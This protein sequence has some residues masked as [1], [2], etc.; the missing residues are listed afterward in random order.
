MENSKK[1]FIAGINADDSFFAHTEADNLDALNVRVVSS[2][3]GKAGSISNVNGTRLVPNYQSFYNVK[4]VGSY[5]DFTTN[6]VFYFLVNKDNNVST[7]YCYKPEEDNIF[8]VLSDNNLDSTYSLNFNPDKPITG[9]GYIDDILYWTGVDGREPFRINVERGIK[10]NHTDYVTSENAYVTPISKSIVTLIRKPPM[11]PLQITVME[12]TDRDTSFLKSRSHT[13]AYRYVY[14]D[15]ETSVF[16]PTSY[17][18][19]NQDIDDDNHKTSRKIKV[20]FPL[21]EA[22]SYGISQDVHKIQ[23]AVKFDKDTSYFIWK[24]FDN[25]THATEFAAQKNNIEGAISADFYNDVLGFAVDDVN[26]IKLYDTIPYEAEALSIA[27][28]RLFL[29]NIKEGRLNTRQLKS[30]DIDLNIITQSFSDSFNQYDR[31]RGG[32]VSFSHASAYQIGLAFFDFAGRTGGVLTDNAMKVITPERELEL[33]AYNAFINFNLNTE[34]ANSIIPD[35]AEYYAIVRTK[36]LIKDFTITNLSD[37]IRYYKIDSNGGFSVFVEN[38]YPTNNENDNK[39]ISGTPNGTFSDNQHVT[40]DPN[41]EGVAIGLGDLTSYKQGYTYQEGDRI[42][43]ITKDRIIEMAITGQEGRYV[44]CNLIDLNESDYLNTTVL[45]ALDYSIIYEIYSPHKI[46]PNEFYYEAFNGRIIESGGQRTYSDTSGNLIGDVYVRSLAADLS[47]IEDHFHEGKQRST[48]SQDSPIQGNVAY[49]DFPIFYGSGENDLSANTGVGNYTESDDYRYDIKINS[50]GSTDTFVWRRRSRVQLGISTSYSSP[51]SITGSA[52]SLSGGVVI[53]FENTTGHTLNDRWVVSAKTATNSNMDQLA[54]KTMALYKPPP[55][56]TILQG[57]RIKIY[58]IE[59]RNPVGPNNFTHEW[60][61][62]YP[63]NLITETFVSLEELF[64]ETTFGTQ[65]ASAFQNRKYAFSFRRGKMDNT[66]GGNQRIK[67]LDSDGTAPGANV[68]LSDGSDI[69]MIVESRETE[70]GGG[71]DVRTTYSL[72][73]DFA[74]EFAYKSESMNPSNDYFL[75][76]I[77]ITGKPNLVPSEVSSQKKTTGIVFSETKIPGSKINGLSK[78]SALD[79]KR[80]DDA[81]GPLR[82]LQVTSKTQSTGSVL[83]AVSENETTGIYLGEQQL[84]QT[85]SGGQFLAVSSGVIGTMNTLRGSYGTSHP[86]SFVVNEGKAFWFDVK[87]ETVIKYDNNGL[88]AIGDVKMK[89]FFK[90]K[91]NIINSDTIRHF[92]VGTYDDYNS[93]YILTIPRTGEVTT[94]LQQDPYYPDTPVIEIT[95]EGSEPTSKVV[96]VEIFKPWEMQFEMTVIDG[97]GTITFNSP[98]TFTIPSGV[99][100]T[101]S[102]SNITVT[103]ATTGGFTSSN[104]EF[105]GS[106]TLTISGVFGDVEHIILQLNR[107]IQPRLSAIVVSNLITYTNDTELD[108]GAQTSG[109]TPIR[110]TDA[111]DGTFPMF[112]EK[113]LVPSNGTLTI[114]CTSTVPWQFGIADNNS[115]NFTECE[116]GVC[117]DIAAN[118]IT[119]NATAITASSTTI[120]YQP[121]TFNITITGIDEDIDS[122]VIDSRPLKR[123]VFGS[124]TF[125][126]IT[127]SGLSLNSSIVLNKETATEF[128]FVYSTTDTDPS[129][130][131]SG[132]TKVA[133]SGST[134]DMSHTI[135]GLSADTTVYA[136]AY[137]TSNF[138]TRYGVCYNQATGSA[139]NTAPAVTSDSFSSTNNRFTGII[140]SNG[141]STA[142]TNGITE[143]GWVFSSSDN[144]PTIGESGVVKIL[145]PQVAIDSFPY[146][147]TSLNTLLVSG[148]QYYWRAYAK[149]DVGTS[150]GDVKTFTTADTSVGIG[151]FTLQSNSVSGNGGYVQVDVTKNVTTGIVAGDITFVISAST[152]IIEGEEVAVAFTNTQTIDSVQVYIPANYSGSS[153]Y[154]NLKVNLFDGIP[155]LTGSNTPV[156]IQGTI[157]QASSS[158]QP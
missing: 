59:R 9:I 106:G 32:K 41:H 141:G 20:D 108:F 138:G 34:T 69:F 37:S 90:E 42:K 101:P 131:E 72:L 133:L 1:T 102:G 87:N 123:A 128:G 33:D 144:T 63:G 56:G 121:G 103:N 54:D 45:S 124:F 120:G 152:S 13:F 136:K 70:V 135:T 132:V 8:K 91:S 96:T 142:G 53:T 74:E 157:N 116:L 61:V 60:E 94:V 110:V 5:E 38:N 3:E 127:A 25:I 134:S 100:Q 158:F 10:T 79:E 83:L 39:G 51:I 80:L 93:E 139:S 6:N 81:T 111:T 92:V 148:T 4:V 29:G 21:Y 67:I 119:T 129:I 99:V 113:S 65:C 68:S 17:H 109:N 47:A 12:D 153:R 24:E 115:T 19:P 150:Y 147:Y 23:Y 112:E 117:S 50:T 27:R 143:R 118:R 44:L 140:T 62:E 77:Q 137:L 125:D 48:S 156:T 58:Y 75:N 43:L 104:N 55:G 97:V 73:I 64:W 146:T 86:E 40:F 149:N 36:N 126:D 28:N 107:V 16:S 22:E 130:G 46:Q 71:R 84:Q 151:G 98:Y 49:I 18:Y 89:T 35:W 52:Q 15:G 66:N 95:N 145:A 122:I 114:P 155:N 7:I 31:D 26:S 154:I 88:T 105:S 76:W 57:S 11:L 2:S 78:F 85:S 30:T 14:K 82:V